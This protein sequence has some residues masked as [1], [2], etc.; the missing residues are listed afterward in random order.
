MQDLPFGEKTLKLSSKTEIKIPNVIR[1]SIPEQIVR[2]YQSYC[3]ETEF[4]PMSRSSLCRILKVCSA[5][6]RKSLQ[7]L[8]YVSSEGAKAFDDIADVIDKLGDN[9]NN[10]LTWSKELA[11]KLKLAKRYL[12]G[13]YKLKSTVPEIKSICF[14]QDNAG[15]YHSAS[16]LVGVQQLAEKHKVQI[17]VDFSDPQGGKGSCDRKSATIKNHMRVFLNSGHDIET[18][19]QMKTSM[20]SFGGVPGVRV[21]LCGPLDNVKT[22][23]VK[24]EGISLVNNIIYLEQGMKV[25]R[26]YGIGPGKFVPWTAFDVSKRPSA[27]NLKVIE[28]ATHPKA[29]FCPI[30]ARR[31]SKEQSETTS[32]T[33]SA[34]ESSPEESSS[35]GGDDALFACPEEGCMKTYQRYFSLQ[36]HLD[37]GKHNYVLERETLLDK[38]MMRYASNLEHGA[39]SIDNV[40]EDRLPSESLSGEPT[41][42]MG[43]AL[44]STTTRKHRLTDHQKRHLTD[45]FLIG[46]QTGRKADPSEVSRSMRRARNSDGSFLFQTADYLTPKQITSYFS[47]LS[48]KKSVSSP[49]DIDD[50]AQTLPDIGERNIEQLREEVMSEIAI[51]HPIMYDTYSICDLVA[52]SKLSKFAIPMLHDICSHFELDIPTDPGYGTEEG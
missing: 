51:Q 9:Y 29:T 28:D 38:A 31:Q 46:E 13:D 24:W 2:Q 1:S 48:A 18:A 26:A 21:V 7:G 12:K 50:D 6:V 19:E 11:Q 34:S 22:A 45:V 35:T 42:T 8:D 20:E 4:S 37:A 40:V 41:L 16:T 47:R 30:K 32:E 10:G 25:W 44:K 43:W 39:S 23:P 17:R 52:N 3:S 33:E 27:S 36:N 15:C 14:R 49:P 5:S